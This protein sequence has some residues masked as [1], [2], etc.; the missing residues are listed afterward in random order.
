M[1]QERSIYPQKE[2]YWQDPRSAALWAIG[3]GMVQSIW[4]LLGED[5][6]VREYSMAQRRLSLYC[7]LASQLNIEPNMHVGLKANHGS[8][9]WH[10]PDPIPLAEYTIS[11]LVKL[12]TRGIPSKKG[13]EKLLPEFIT[14]V[15]EPSIRDFQYRIITGGLPQSL[16]E[17]A[18]IMLF[19]HVSSNQ[20]GIDPQ[21]VDLASLL[22]T[23]Y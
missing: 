2:F 12:A 10:R 11:A 16:Q 6:G 4:Y 18:D 22:A 20:L 9:F 17:W 14:N 15:S 21:E 19:T 5:E 23:G 13:V 1:P 8:D 7:N 3:Y